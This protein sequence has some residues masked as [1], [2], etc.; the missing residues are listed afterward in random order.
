MTWRKITQVKDTIPASRFV[1]AQLFSLTFDGRWLKGLGM[2]SAVV[3]PAVSG[4][5]NEKISS[6]F[7]L[8]AKQLHTKALF[9]KESIGYNPMKCGKTT[10]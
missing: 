7:H 8:R 10:R 4:K 5:R 2:K 6:I 9:Q 1:G 3:L